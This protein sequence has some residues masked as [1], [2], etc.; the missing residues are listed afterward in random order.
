MDK[1]KTISFQKYTIMTKNFKNEVGDFMKQWIQKFLVSAVA[2]VT[3]GVITPSHTIWNNLL[4]D[5]ASAKSQNYG[6]THSTYI[7]S[8]FDLPKQE[9]DLISIAKEQSYEKFGTKVGPKIQNE[10]DQV[11]FP[12]MQEVMDQVLEDLD[13]QEKQQIA[14]TERPS[15]NYSEKMFNVYNEATGEDIIRFH[16]RTENRP[17]D[18]YFYNFH[19]HLADDDFAKHHDLGDVYWSKNTPPKWLS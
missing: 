8:S 7:E 11:I 4:E 17:L 3:L 14:I 19:Y 9:I 10:F 6:E 18:G 5:Q 1:S 16:V 12:K 13:E 2:V 15:G